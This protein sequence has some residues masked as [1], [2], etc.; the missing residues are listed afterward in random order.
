MSTKVAERTSADT[1]VLD[2]WAVG[3]ENQV[4]GLQF[5]HRARIRPLLSLSQNEELRRLAAFG[6][7]DALS[8]V[9]PV[10]TGYERDTAS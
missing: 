6:K 3:S 7:H 8:S 4:G 10:A 1:Q 2:A 9:A 5:S